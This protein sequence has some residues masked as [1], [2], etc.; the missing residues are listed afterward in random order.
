MYSER[1]EEN[2]F[3][4]LALAK[5]SYNGTTVAAALQNAIHTALNA[6]F[7]V[8]VLYDLNDNLI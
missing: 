5:M 4:Q 8:D 2:I 6:I 7:S 3:K 1:G